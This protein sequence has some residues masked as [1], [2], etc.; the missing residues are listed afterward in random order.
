[1]ASLSV[2]RSSGVMSS[3]VVPLAKS[4]RLVPMSSV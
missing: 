1:M 4:P 2:P 3:V